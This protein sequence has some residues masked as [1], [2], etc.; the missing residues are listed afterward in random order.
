MMNI[1]VPQECERL[2]VDVGLAIDAPNSA[3]WL[4]KDEKSFVIGVE[5]SPENIS[6][7]RKGRSS[8]FHLPYLCLDND[9]VLLKGDPVCKI[10]N[11]F[12][13]IECA[14]DNVDSPTTAP[15]Y[16]TDERNTGC[17]SLLKPT[18]KLRLDVKKVHQAK[19]NSLKQILDE[20]YENTSRFPYITLLKSDAQGK[21]LDVI[22]STRDYLDKVLFIKME[23]RTDGQYE[24][25]QKVSEIEEFMKNNK[26]NLYRDSHYDYVYINYS[27][28][29]KIGGDINLNNLRDI[30]FSV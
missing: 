29:E 12:H 2:F 17:S 27:L 28:L 22:K 9:H 8:D 26:F 18:E 24:N 7:L 19:V 23:V 13:L 10:E 21:D 30:I 3:S 1:N 16:M 11:R 15:F 5:P 14:I 20:F 6:V 4:L 25:E